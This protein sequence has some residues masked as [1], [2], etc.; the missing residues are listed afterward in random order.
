MG[1]RW[2]SSHL[3]YPQRENGCPL[4]L[5]SFD[6]IFVICFPLCSK[7]ELVGYRSPARDATRIEL[8]R[9]GNRCDTKGDGSGCPSFIGRHRG[10]N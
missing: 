1:N 6:E 8:I 4:T 9:R 3:S 10:G 7:Q 2:E 5:P